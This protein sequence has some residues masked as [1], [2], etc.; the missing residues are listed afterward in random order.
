MSK[1]AKPGR[2]NAV[3]IRKSSKPQDEQAQVDNVRAMLKAKGVPV[4]DDRWFT[5]TVSRRKVKADAEFRRLMDL[6]EA[7]RVS[8]VY[9]E[10]QDRWGTK[11]RPELFTLLGTLR[12][13]DT[14]LYDLRADRD[15][16]EKDLAT[17]LLMFVGSVKS[18]QEL[19]D[20]AYR[21]LRSRV[22]NFLR[23]GSWPTGTHPFGYAKACYGPD[24]GTLKWVWHP[25]NRSKGQVFNAGPGGLT[26]GSDGVKIPRKHREDIIKLV[27]NR[28]ADYVRAVRLVYDLYTRVGL[29][30]RQISTRLN[31]E[32]MLFNG[33]HFTH[34]AVT[35]IL[36]NPAY[37]GDTVFGKVQTGELYTFNAEGGIVEAK[38][39]AD[40]RNRDVSRCLVMRDTHEPLVDRKTWELAED[41]LKA[42]RRR[43]SHAPR[44]PAYYLKQI[45][46]CGHCGKSMAAR[47]EN[48]RVVY[49]CS[50]Y[51]K[52]RQNGHPSSCGYHSIKHE[53]AERLLL[54]KIEELNLPF[55]TA[56]SEGARANLEQRLARLGQEDEASVSQWE[57]WI[58]EAVNDL[59]DY[60]DEA[61]E[62]DDHR[63]VQRL[64][65]LALGFYCDKTTGSFANL[66]LAL[67]EFRKA[68]K[69]AE[70]QA[71]E[72]AKARL[73]EL[74][75]EHRNL[76]LTWARATENMQDVLKREIVA[77]E[78]Q[79]A[80]WEPRT[81]PISERL[82]KLYQ[83][84]A[85]RQEERQR[86]LAEWPKLENREKGEALRRLFDTV[87]LR[88]DREFHP[89][90]EKPTRPRKMDRPGRYT[91]T[92]RRD[93][94]K[95][96]LASLDSGSS[97]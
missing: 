14:R 97:K 96:H 9:V 69:A 50:S 65:K 27:P 68:L 95:W 40:E 84:E 73:T 31:G 56:A 82:E 52:G 34:S 28:N 90:R 44:N 41:K 43:T 32:G 67:R 7:D 58:G 87:E 93:R 51:L 21:S 22:G 63:T 80:E 61:Y 66:P 8:T 24:G 94:I 85:E 2:V 92:L 71:V 3:F 25:V 47:S 83:A 57:A 74:R 15:L 11:D 86:L 53:D 33:K 17:E 12:E 35:G 13:H 77:L 78:G 49:V 62:L 5:T 79:M 16:T 54:D 75:E 76:T 59:I 6:V 70:R 10:S 29:S 36:R 88:W 23:T 60:L 48:G 64:R 26:P 89:A 72:R 1:K 30:R 39:V 91:Y 55:D 19:K 18:E 4:D 37:A 42:E 45:F 20:I 38:E 81:L 46:V